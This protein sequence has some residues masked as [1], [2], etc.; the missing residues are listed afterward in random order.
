M[1]CEI[2]AVKGA[3]FVLW[4]KPT[5]ADMD[6]VEAALN[7]S[8]AKFGGPITCITRVPAAAPA[9]D[10]EA[11]KH[12]NSL[13]PRVTQP[14]TTYHVLLEGDGFLAAMKR[15]ILTSLFQL[16]FHKGSFF[17]HSSIKEVGLRVDKAVRVHVEDVLQ[18]AK[19][20]GLLD[21]TKA[22]SLPPPGRAQPTL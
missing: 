13:M 14:C 7:D 2:V 16:G 5:R 10:A 20:G 18:L 17:V 21:R 12:L 15:G 3:L 11:R 22:L 4:G 1:S 9:P 8:V 6:R 19:R